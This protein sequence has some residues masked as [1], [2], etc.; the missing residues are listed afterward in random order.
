MFNLVSESSFSGAAAKAT[1][2][3]T[4]E[5]NVRRGKKE[6]TKITESKLL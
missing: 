1:T 2:K 4:G 5:F 6:K 3:G